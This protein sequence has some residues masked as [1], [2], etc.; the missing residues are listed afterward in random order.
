MGSYYSQHWHPEVPNDKSREFCQRYSATHQKFRAGLVALTYDTVHLIAD[1]IRRAGSIK[2]ED[3]QTALVR[4]KD[5]QGITGKITF[6]ENRDPLSK[7]LVIL[8]FGKAASAFHK[9]VHADN[10]SDSNK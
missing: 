6:D 4:T 7:P 9:M 8:R 2:A 1:A 5:F 10:V 3:I